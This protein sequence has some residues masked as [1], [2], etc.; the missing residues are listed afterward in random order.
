MIHG[1]PSLDQVIS[2]ASSASGVLPMAGEVW[3]RKDGRTATVV[4]VTQSAIGP[5][6]VREDDGR[7]TYRTRDGRF[8]IFGLRG[9]CNEDLM[10]LAMED[11]ACHD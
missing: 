6:T 9:G 11:E 8:A 3:L 4:E 7:T 5:L 10:T 1:I 2:A